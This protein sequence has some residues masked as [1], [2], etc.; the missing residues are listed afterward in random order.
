MGLEGVRL[1]MARQR[2]RLKECADLG[3]A[4]QPAWRGCGRLRGP[5][6]VIPAWAVFLGV[7]LA[8][9]TG[10]V[11][12]AEEQGDAAFMQEL[13]S[14]QALLE[15]GKAS[16]S[17][18]VFKRANSMRRNTS[19]DCF[20][21]MARAYKQ[22]GEHKKVMQMCDRILQYA[23][24][25]KQL[26]CLTHNLKGTSLTAQADPKDKKKLRA[27]EAEFRQ[28]LSLDNQQTVVRFNLGFVL[29][30]QGRDEEGIK[31]LQT[32]LTQTS[33]GPM[34]E[35]AR[36][37]IAKPRRAREHYAQPFSLMTSQG[38]RLTLDGL[39]GRVVLLDFWATWC[40]PCVQAIPSL[41]RLYRK[42]SQAPFV[43]I[44]VSADQDERTWRQF[45]GKNS[46]LW[47]QC[48][49]GDNLL[50]RTFAISAFP[51]YIL[52]DEEG[53]IRYR[54]VGAGML[55]ETLIESEVKKCLEALR[56]KGS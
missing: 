38:E 39:R 11:V 12:P 10:A 55:N 31:E 54:S 43:I 21:G 20:L 37:L 56:P 23:A 24:N 35:N 13:N 45:I 52:I 22:L 6:R 29:L 42:F 50:R 30:K 40:D 18:K 9:L 5:T 17:L 49:D 16:A 51:T 19:V 26:C 33:T 36:R 46:M 32:L 41:S 2:T 27:A 34:A 15:E 1:T 53:V 28:A 44:S 47:P 4:A 7:A 25:D 3:R 8:M 14:A 48:W